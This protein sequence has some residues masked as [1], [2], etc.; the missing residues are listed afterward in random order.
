MSAPYGAEGLSDL[1]KRLRTPATAQ[2]AIEAEEED[3]REEED[4]NWP[5]SE[6]LP[7]EDD[8]DSTLIDENGGITAEGYALLAD[9]ERQGFFV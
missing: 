1:R 2:P 7:H 5:P 4:E 9:L 6:Q 8:E 3:D